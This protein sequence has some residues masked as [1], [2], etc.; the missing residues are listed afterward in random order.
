MRVEEHPVYPEWR[1][2]I[3]NLKEAAD[4]YDDLVKQKASDAEINGARR[5]LAEAQALYDKARDKIGQFDN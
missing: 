1:Y 4:A 3:D 2:A 5:R